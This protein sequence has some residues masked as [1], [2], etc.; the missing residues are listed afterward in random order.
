ML[1]SFFLRLFG[2]LLSTFLVLV[3]GN[4]PPHGPLVRSLVR[5]IGGFGDDLFRSVGGEVFNERDDEVTASRMAEKLASVLLERH[6]LY[7]S[8]EAH[9]IKIERPN[10]RRKLLLDPGQIGY[11]DT[12]GVPIPE[13]TPTCRRFL[14]VWFRKCAFGYEE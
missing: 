13:P 9:D 1:F 12:V 11:G 7:P 4:G 8:G 6:A 3:N 5:D 14:N 2:A 10:G